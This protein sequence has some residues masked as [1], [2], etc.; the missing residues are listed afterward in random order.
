MFEQLAAQVGTAIAAD[1]AR[2][3]AGAIEGLN[4]LLD[5]LCPH[6]TAE[7]VAQDALDAYEAGNL[8]ADAAMKVVAVVLA[9]K[10]KQR[11]AAPRRQPQR[12]SPITV[13]AQEVYDPIAQLMK[14]FA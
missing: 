6:H 7:D 2:N 12:S 4:T 14:A 5:S 3:P 11:A 13:Q 10:E 9:D 8:S 1:I